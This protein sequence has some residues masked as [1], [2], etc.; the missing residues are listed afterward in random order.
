[1]RVTRRLAPRRIAALG[2]SAVLAIGVATAAAPSARVE[3]ADALRISQ[4]AIGRQ[5]DGLTFITS[6]G[7]S[8]T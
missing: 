4:A 3:E 7:D 2:V 1:M 6:Q 8:L 5:L